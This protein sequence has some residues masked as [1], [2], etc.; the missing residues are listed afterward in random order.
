MEGRERQTSRVR[1]RET[2]EGGREGSARAG[3]TERARGARV[4]E[5]SVTSEESGMRRT[6]CDAAGLRLVA[7]RTG[8]AMA[9]GNRI[10]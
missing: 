10:G 6:V 8:L 5:R 3:G 7:V 2:G 1:E 9:T 4:A